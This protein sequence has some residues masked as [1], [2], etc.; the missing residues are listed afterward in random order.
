MKFKVANSTLLSCLQMADKVVTTNNLVPILENFLIRIEDN[1]LTVTGSNLENS[2]TSSI[3]IESTGANLTIALS[4]R[5]IVD[6]LR[7]FPDEPIEFTINED[8]MEVV[9]KSST[10]EYNFVGL[11]GDDFPQQ[12]A[13]NDG[14]KSFKVPANV[15][16]TGIVKTISSTAVEDIRPTMMGI[17]VN[18]ETDK[19]TF[20]A[21]DAHKLTRYSYSGITSE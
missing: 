20:V 6:T 7:T 11:R 2:I 3:E 4:A 8:N 15:I 18:L 13:L 5:L 10:G 17:F 9:I 1:K 14:F 16:V 21:T 12:I 19:L